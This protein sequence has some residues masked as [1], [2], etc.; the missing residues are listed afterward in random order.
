MFHVWLVL[1][2]LVTFRECFLSQL[3]VD[4]SA[5]ISDIFCKDQ[6]GIMDVIQALSANFCNPDCRLIFQEPAPFP[7]LAGATG[8]GDA[9]QERVAPPAG[10]GERRQSRLSI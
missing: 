10:C 2:Q 5:V 9:L 7:P 1:L 3:S 4:T 6:Q 8:G